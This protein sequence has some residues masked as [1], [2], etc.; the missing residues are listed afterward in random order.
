M[1]ELL[2][3]EKRIFLQMIRNLKGYFG[4]LAM[5]PTLYARHTNSIQ[6]LI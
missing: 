4:I 6:E 1:I 3:I 2:A 5:K